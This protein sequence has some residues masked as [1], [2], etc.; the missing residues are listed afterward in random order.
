MIDQ[1]PIP[2]PETVDDVIARWVRELREEFDAA[3]SVE[4]SLVEWIFYEVTKHVNRSIAQRKRYC[5]EREI[6]HGNINRRKSK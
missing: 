5:R 4:R 2:L 6:N 3:F 1:H